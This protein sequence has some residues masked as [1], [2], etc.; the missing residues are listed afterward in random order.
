M[1]VLNYRGVSVALL[2]LFLLAACGPQKQ[3]DQEV[4]RLRHR[5]LA[6]ARMGQS[7]KAVEVIEKALE[8]DPDRY[9]L[10]ETYWKLRF[11]RDEGAVEELQ[12]LEKENPGT[13]VYSRLLSNLLEDPGERLDAGRRAMR[14]ITDEP[15]LYISLG[16]T[17]IQLDM[18]DSAKA[19]FSR[20]LDLEP[21]S[22]TASL[23]LA[24]LSEDEGD[25]LAAAAG[26][27]GIVEHAES[28]ADHDDAVG[29]LF[30]LYWGE[31]EIS[32]AADVARASMLN[33]ADP[34][35]HDGMA[36]S[37]A[38][39]RLEIALAE[40]LS[41]NA[42][43]GMNA[44]WIE[45]KFPEID[46]D[47]AEGAARRYRGYLYDTLGLVYLQSGRTSG[48]IDALEESM[49][50]VSY[51]DADLLTRLAGA[52]R[53]AGMLDKAIESLLDLLASSMNEDALAQ[54]GEFYSEQHGDT[55]GLGALI[56]ERRSEVTRPSTDFEMTALTG[57]TVSLSDFRG[58]V[59]LLNFWFPT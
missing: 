13:P 50:L 54:L 30:E 21:G 20:A 44:A 43:E 25:L 47:W 35:V 36:R 56:A 49:E 40:S 46:K 59:V 51:P 57:E 9:S 48:A 6:L 29:E 10:L 58:D 4:E 45:T 41:L 28:E 42:I 8:L 7:G 55:T 37:M 34:W 11:K 17:F 32:R 19:Y 31:Q 27:R 52:Y 15:D 26:Y 14:L 23:S 1:A 33:V 12:A 39:S 16:R 2:L 18:A 5:S 3:A 24:R 38:E 22:S 53:D